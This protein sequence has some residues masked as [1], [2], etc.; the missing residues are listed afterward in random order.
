MELK[1]YNLKL[2]IETI[3][4]MQIEAANFDDAYSVALEDYKSGNCDGQDEGEL[5]YLN[6]IREIK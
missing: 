3:Y 5:I 1:K 2:K 6:D 4:P